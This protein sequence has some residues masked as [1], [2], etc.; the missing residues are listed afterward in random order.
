[1]IN[2]AD[3]RRY[4]ESVARTVPGIKSVVP[5]SV[6]A[7]MADR[8]G[9]VS[10]DDSPTLFFLVP[11]AEG[12]GSTDAWKE[13]NLCVIFVMKRFNPRVST[14]FDALVETQPLVE[15]V[16][17]ALFDGDYDGCRPLGVDAGTLSTI[18]E[19]EFFGDWAG[20]SVAFT[21]E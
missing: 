9:S 19:T 18:P 5:L 13:E 6:D 1:M 10:E 11:S 15:A 17:S 4:I 14:S 2:L 12:K 16:K 7:S 21:A 20:W 8:V 3:Y